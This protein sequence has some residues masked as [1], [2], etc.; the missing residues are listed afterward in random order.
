MALVSALNF[1][2][3]AVIFSILVSLVLFASPSLRHNAF[4]LISELP[5]VGTH[6]LLRS[7]VLTGD[8]AAASIAL[9][10]Q[11]DLALWLRKEESIQLPGIIKNTES[12]MN[13]SG[14]STKLAPLIPFLQRLVKADPSIYKSH[15]FLAKALQ[16][17]D[18]EAALIELKQA[19]NFSGPEPEPYR[20]AISI[21]HRAGL[22]SDFKHWC[23]KYNRYQFGGIREHEAMN[24]FNGSGLRRMAVEIR[25]D[26]SQPPAYTINKGL[27]LN[28]RHTYHFNFLSQ[29][30]ANGI[31]LHVPTPAGVIF[32]IKDLVLFDQGVSRRIARSDFFV[33]SKNGYHLGQKILSTGKNDVFE[34]RLING[35]DLQLDGL[36]ISMLVTRA[37]LNELAACNL[38]RNPHD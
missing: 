21:A 36:A 17:D 6:F 13:R 26:G 22:E 7:A 18:P 2:A 35:D 3:W 33:F 19:I 1:S 12:I 9:N 8:T 32:D 23:N 28:E 14:T 11:L 37:R 5:S 27:I 24:E 38:R 15:L 16:Y 30:T 29:R 20:L 10:R 4:R 25:G 34:F 31:Y